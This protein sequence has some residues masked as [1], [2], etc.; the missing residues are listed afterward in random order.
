[1]RKK[2]EK[3]QEKRGKMLRKRKKG[4]GNRIKGIE[5]RK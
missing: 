1:L 2:C 3:G 4:A 5:K